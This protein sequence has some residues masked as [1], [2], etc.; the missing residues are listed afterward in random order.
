M[1]G[2]RHLPLRPHQDPRRDL[3]DRHAAADGQRL[4][5]RRPRL[6]LHPHRPDRPLPADARPRGLLPDG[7]GRQ[8]PADRAPGA[9][10]LRRPLRPVAALRPGLRPAGEAATPSDQIPISPAQLRRAV[11]AADRRG[12]EGVRDAVAPARAVGR[13][14]APLHDDRRAAHGRVAAR[15]SCATSP[16][17]RPTRPRRRRCGTSTSAPRS[18]RPSWRTAS[19]PA[20]TTGSPSTA[21]TATVASSRP[22]GPSCSRRASRWSPIPTTSA[23]S[24]CSART[25][26]TPLFGVEV[27]VAR[28]PPGRAREG[29]R[30][31]DDLHVRRPHRRHLVARA[32]AA[33]PRRHRPRRPP[34][35]GRRRTAW[36]RPAALRA[37]SPAR[38]STRRART[39]VEHA[40][41]VRRPDGEPRRSRT[42]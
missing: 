19:V 41:R 17:A 5:A 24:R 11:R 21:R 28:A 25:V 12:R 3:L 40:A 16:A 1:G 32:A 29:H 31:R 38:R 20:P 42:R 9:E 34:A 35:A 2:P 13:L 18:R 27:P 37:S 4:A 15:R 14:V 7:L 33:D 26:R 8:R 36:T 23:T 10:L 6:L 39:I 22:P 30:H